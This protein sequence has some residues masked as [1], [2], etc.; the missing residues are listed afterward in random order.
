[1]QSFEHG[2]IVTQENDFKL[3]KREKSSFGALAYHQILI[4]CVVFSVM[5]Q[6]SIY[7]IEKE[8]DHVT[9]SKMANKVEHLC[10]ER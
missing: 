10:M 5:L 9:G 1:M 3:M 2:F 7:N 4:A 8:T 6:T